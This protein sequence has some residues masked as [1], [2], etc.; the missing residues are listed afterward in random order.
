MSQINVERLIGRLAT[1]EALRRRFE[2]SPRE[3]LIQMMESGMN[4]NRCELEAL[5][6]LDPVALAH[7]TRTIDSRLQRID[8]EREPC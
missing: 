1:D 6:A 2:D 4:L 7:F 3:F 5:A 8:V